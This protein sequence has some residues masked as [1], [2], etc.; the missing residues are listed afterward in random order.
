MQ[1]CSYTIC[2]CGECDPLSFAGSL[3]R[4]G[5]AE[6]KVIKWENVSPD[7]LRDTSRDLGALKMFIT[8]ILSGD[9]NSGS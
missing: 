1:K 2:A 9:P 7:G 8:E 3:S 5:S 6:Q 4:T